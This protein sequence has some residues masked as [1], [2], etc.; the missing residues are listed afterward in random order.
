MTTE[1][2]AL[3]FALIAT[4]CFSTSSL[5]FA[6]YSKLI[7]PFW[8][9]CLKTIVCFIA[10]VLAQ[11]FFIGWYYPKI[12]E[13]VALAFSGFL[14]LFLADFLLL[15]AYTSL[16]AARTLM[17]FGFQPLFI[18]G[19]S[20]FLFNQNFTASKLLALLFLIGCIGS[21]SIEK[22][23]EVGHW[24]SRG[25]GLAIAAIFL[26]GTGVIISRYVFDVNTNMHV[27]QGNFYRTVGAIIAFYIFS[28]WRPLKILTNLKKLSHKNK[29]KVLFASFMGTFVSL[30]FYLQAIR[31]GHL[32]SVGAIGLS[33]PMFAGL[34]ES[35]IKKKLPSKYFILAFTFFIIGGFIL[36]RSD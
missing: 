20:F 29:S 16:G 28:F 11:V 22:Y 19:A 6:D 14:G 13:V 23:K 21:L 36:L 27:I 10:V 25:F 1:H 34:I 12:F 32:A 18:G 2:S 4:I 5:V 15:K 31:D 26:D 24:E 7:S 33:G 17:L 30:L 9:N 35:A 3:Y 8:M